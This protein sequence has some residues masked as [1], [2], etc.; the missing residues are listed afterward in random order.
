MRP[1]HELDW[2]AS[3]TALQRVWRKR[4]RLRYVSDAVREGRRSIHE[5]RE[6]LRGLPR[7]RRLQLLQVE[8]EATLRTTRHRCVCDDTIALNLESI[9]D[10]DRGRA[11]V[12]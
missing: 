4:V 2:R 8:R 10:G 11:L 7:L 9:R 6:D 12:G 3:R 1:R 5:V